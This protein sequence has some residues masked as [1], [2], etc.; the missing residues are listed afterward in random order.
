MSKAKP[1]LAHTMDRLSN[2]KFDTSTYIVLDSRIRR[3]TTTGELVHK[4]A[5][6]PRPKAKRSK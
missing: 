6:S 3:D 5:A 1:T 4:K 2:Y